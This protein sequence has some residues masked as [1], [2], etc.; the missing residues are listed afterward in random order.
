MPQKQTPLEEIMLHT[1]ASNELCQIT[2]H[3]QTRMQQR[4]ISNEDVL[5]ILSHG[6]S[7]DDNTIILTRKDVKHA[8]DNLLNYLKKIEREVDNRSPADRVTDLGKL[9]DEL[10]RIISQQRKTM[11][12]LQRLQDYKIVFDG[13]MLITCYRCS[14]KTIKRAYKNFH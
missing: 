4:S 11:Q 12:R 13:D 10:K 7:F 5:A 8:L 1:T 9:D 6:T 3:A 2:K 14:R